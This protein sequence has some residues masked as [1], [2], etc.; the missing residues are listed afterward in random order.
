M[1]RFFA[2]V[3]GV[4]SLTSCASL[5]KGANQEL[6][7]RDKISDN[8]APV[9]FVAGGSVVPFTYK[10][11]LA[12][13]EW[14][15]CKTE[16]AKATA[17]LMHSDRAGFAKEKL[18]SGWIAQTFLASGYDVVTVNRPGYGGSDGEPDFIGAESLLS[19]S[20]VLPAALTAAGIPNP[21]SVVWGYDTGATAAALA[22]KRLG[23]I[24][25]AILGGGVYDYDETL[26]TT[27]DEYLRTDLTAIKRAG[28][29]KAFEDR[30]VAYDLNG[31]PGNIVIYHG[32]NDKAVPLAQAK[33]FHDSLVSN[34]HFRVTYQVVVG[35]GHDLP[36]PYHRHLI[37]AMLKQPV[38]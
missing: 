23:G 32:M 11:Q 8:I 19:L 2:L 36:W 35:Q 33:A 10:G 26:R 1:S 16:G 24:K 4:T 7:V 27:S 18:C 15:S 38:Q 6:E 17:L 30:S 37:E 34:G 5:P 28:G 9:P 20:V 13:G 3:F 31:L 12:R 25:T 21:I 14:I 22:A 29:D